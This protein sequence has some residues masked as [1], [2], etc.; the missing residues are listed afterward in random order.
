[1]AR[2]GV[3]ALLVWFGC[4]GGCFA[5][6]I[7]QGYAAPTRVPTSLDIEEY[8]VDGNSALAT[9]DV[10]RAV[11]P[12]LGPSRSEDAIE[13]ARQ[14][15]LKV[16]REHGY[17]AVQVT[18]VDKTPDA[19]GTIHFQV[20]EVR[21]GRVRVVGARFFLPS[22]VRHEMPSIKEGALFDT[23]ALN[24]EIGIANSIPGREVTPIP[25]PSRTP[26]VL[27]LDLVVHDQLPIHASVDINNAHARF[28]TPLRVTG[29][30]SYDNLFQRG[31][32][33]SISY[34]TAPQNP[35]DSKVLILGY[36]I[37]F[38]GTPYGV[39]VSAIQSNSAIAS[40]AAT[41]I[42]SNGTDI[43]LRGTAELP[44]TDRYSQNV[45]AGAD[46]KDYR[47]DT[48][49]VGTPV[50]RVPVTYFPLTATY[51]GIVHDPRNLDIITLALSLAPPRGGSN[52]ATID[53]NRYEA[54]GQQLY[55]RGGI[56]ATRNL[57][58]DFKLH[59]RATGQVAN[60]ALISNEQLPLGGSSSV[61]GYY[62]V[63][64]PVDNG[65]NVSVEAIGPSFPD[66]LG[67]WI[68]ARDLVDEARVMA[69]FD[70]GGG[71]NRSP[72]PGVSYRSVL[73]SVGIGAN[74]RLFNHVDASLAW[75]TPLITDGVNPR[76]TTAGS[77]EI[78]FR[79]LTE[80]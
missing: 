75:A 59:A 48:A 35:G 62:E 37:P 43:A 42:I 69:F 54:R 76:V 8:A 50:S 26:G 36:R 67:S 28:S 66:L 2:G 64:S 29:S 44:D 7:A 56:D 65:Y 20:S 6:S 77:H 38:V 17:Q 3:S 52:Q 13:Q 41:N 19:Q 45:E 79:V 70:Q 55:F 9:E 11:Y 73:A 74:A 53:A 33:L 60:E 78:L 24:R 72:L 40:V 23:K 68:N 30:A 4:L 12:F 10:E 80:Y 61:R 57:P 58:D 39:H 49:S 31:Q 51:T 1:M 15:L 27:N 32:S 25:K 34:I 18:T 63:E 21:I 46:Y 47:A 5:V 22:E 14:A 71:Y 16:Y